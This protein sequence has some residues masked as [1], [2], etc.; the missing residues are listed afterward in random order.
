MKKSTKALL[1]GAAIAGLS[2]GSAFAIKLPA[3]KIDLGGKDKQ[4]ETDKTG[5]VK[6]QMFEKHKDTILTAYDYLAKFYK[7]SSDSDV[8][9][10][11]EAAQKTIA[12]SEAALK[13]LSEALGGSSLG[14]YNN[15][16]DDTK[17]ISFGSKASRV[18]S[19]VGMSKDRIT[20]LQRNLYSTIKGR[21]GWLEGSPAVEKAARWRA[22]I[23]QY[24]AT[25]EKIDANDPKIAEAK[26]EYIPRADA[27][28]KKAMEQLED[29]RME[30]DKYSGSDL[31]S[32]KKELASIYTKK[33]NNKIARISIVT[34]WIPKEEIAWNDSSI[35]WEEN[36]YIAAHIAID[37][38]K[39]AMV[40]TVNYFK[41]KNEKGFDPI[42]IKGIAPVYPVLSKNLMK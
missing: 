23:D 2:L 24:F 25:L 20:Q 22:E 5:D 8:I 40:Y 42:R 13:E 31:E 6:V 16:N 39:T 19:Y 34:S 7:M 12:I 17:K 11:L 28:Y 33:Y 1:M 15:V 18:S 29:M 35:W 4:A 32:L 10:E 41:K 27:A 36:H 9:E 21:T 37:D 38:G 14:N 30:G 26:K 3:P